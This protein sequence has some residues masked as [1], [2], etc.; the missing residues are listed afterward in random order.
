[1]KLHPFTTRILSLFAPKNL[2]PIPPIPA[3]ELQFKDFQASISIDCRRLGPQYPWNWRIACRNPFGGSQ[4]VPSLL[5]HLMDRP[6]TIYPIQFGFQ[7]D[8]ICVQTTTP[9]HV[10]T[11]FDQL[12]LDGGFLVFRT[13][14]RDDGW[15]KFV[16]VMRKAIIPGLFQQ[17]DQNTFSID[18]RP[19]IRH[20]QEGSTTAA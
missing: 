20:Q 19:L 4:S 18:I 13:N 2:V 11:Q 17:H 1:M 3:R 16:E 15:E 9:H 12:A 14:N 6:F 5:D 7:V 8:A 10:E